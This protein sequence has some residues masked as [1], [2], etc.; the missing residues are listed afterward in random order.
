M[1]HRI[2]WVAVG[3][4]VVLN[5]ALLYAAFVRNTGESRPPTIAEPA[6]TR[7]VTPSS[8][9]TSTPSSTATKPA[10]HSASKTPS[11]TPTKTGAGRATKTPNSTPTAPGTPSPTTPLGLTAVTPSATGS[12]ASAPQIELTTRSYFARPFETVRISGTYDGP[13]RMLR[14]EQ[15]HGHRWSR[16]PLPARTDASGRFT[17][18]VEL[19]QRGRHELRVVDPAGNARSAVVTVVIG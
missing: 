12:T 8:T 11:S 16:F 10:A 13:S 6:V 18:Y 19:G 3:V 5:I 1:L 17:A 15:R 7:T 14:T 2:S 9:P 4:L